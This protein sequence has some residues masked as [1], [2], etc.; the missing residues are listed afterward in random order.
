MNSASPTSGF[1]EFGARGPFAD[2]FHGLAGAA[3]VDWVD[4]VYMLSMLL[5]GGALILG[6]G[7][8]LAAVGG[9][10]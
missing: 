6:V 4:W 8:R 3:W 10:I 2:F 9:I 1:L 7:A 5:I